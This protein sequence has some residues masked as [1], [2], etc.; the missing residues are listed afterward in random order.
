MKVAFLLQGGQGLYGAERAT[1]SLI[2]GLVAAGVGVRVLRLCETRLGASSADAV[3]QALRV[4]VADIPVRGRFSRAAIRAIRAELAAWG[5]DIL[6]ATGY[7]ADLHGGLA[8]EWGRLLPVVSTVHGWLFRADPKERLFFHVNLWALRRMSRVIV[9]SRFY[10]RFLR[11][12]GFTPLQLARIPTGLQADAVAT[13]AEGAALWES[14]D[15]PFVF[16][17]LGRLSEEKDHALFLRA[18]ARLAK[19]RRESPVPWRL[20]IAGEGHL[21]GRI[22]R[23]AERLGLADR[24]DMPGRMDP[25]DFF[26]RTHVLVQCSRVENQ[27]LGVME[28]M[29]WARPC[30]ATEAGGLPELLDDGETGKVLHG[31]SPEA[32]S[33]EMEHYLL[34]PEQARDD[35]RRARRKLLRGFPVKDWIEDHIGLYDAL[36]AARPRR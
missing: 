14:A 6:H 32:L 28:A 1:V 36:L 27:P 2:E 21:E 10:E 22:R 34:H 31:R 20:R 26:R 5:A 17:M 19:R 7:K 30:L 24:L 11:A 18:A 25:G 13:E 29:A 33:L 4:P 35:G 12:R 8:A 3:A 16:G 9:L 15:A 23:L